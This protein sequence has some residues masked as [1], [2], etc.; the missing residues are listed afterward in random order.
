MLR[1]LWIVIVHAARTAAP[2]QPMHVPTLRQA[3]ALYLLV[4]DGAAARCEAWTIAPEAGGRGNLVRDAAGE[5]DELAFEIQDRAV[6]L[7]DSARTRGDDSAS[8]SCGWSLGDA[9]EADDAVVVGGARWFRTAAACEDARAAHRRVAVAPALGC[10][11]DATPP[12]RAAATHAR[13]DRLLARGGTL[14]SRG[15]ARC[16]PVRIRPAPAGG[17]GLAGSLAWTVVRDD[18]VRGTTGYD[19]EYARGADAITL[20][21][22]GTTWADGGAEGFG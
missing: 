20:L 2:P 18:G 4:A 12:A 17:G 15:D 22:P 16:T 5:H 9:Y 7:M 11:L 3:G 1:W 13:F 19:F 14:Y 6:V 10:A 21:G 8:Q